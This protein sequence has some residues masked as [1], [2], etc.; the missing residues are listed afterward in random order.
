MPLVSLKAYVP[1]PIQI[2]LTAHSQ[3]FTC[4]PARL[5]NSGP[6]SSSPASL[7]WSESCLSNSAHPLS[8][9]PTPTTGSLLHRM[10]WP[11][12]PPKTFL[13][14]TLE[15]SLTPLLL[16][17]GTFNC[18][19]ILLAQLEI[20]PESNH[21][22]PPL[23]PPCPSHHQLPLDYGKSILAGLSASNMPGALGLFST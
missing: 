23:L 7:R 21:F 19:E 12:S 2:P 20:N 1:P 10:R 22:P 6:A 9:G 13:P 8:S 5:L 4:T 16:S 18:K 3:M 11:L 15:S 17:R 14:K